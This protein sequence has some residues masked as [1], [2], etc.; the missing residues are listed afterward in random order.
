MMPFAETWMD[1]ETLILSKPEK[2]K[3]MVSLKYLKY[4]TIEP[5]YEIETYSWTRRTAWGKGWG[6]D[7]VGGWGEQM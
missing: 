1:L 7:G 3:Y 5:I 2:D 4:D 6:R